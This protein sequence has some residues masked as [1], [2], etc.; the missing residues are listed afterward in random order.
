MPAWW[1]LD[2]IPPSFTVSGVNL[3]IKLMGIDYVNSHISGINGAVII[4]LWLISSVHHLSNLSGFGKILIQFRTQTGLLSARDGPHVG[5][6]N[7]TIRDKLRMVVFMFPNPCGCHTCC[8]VPLRAHT[9]VTQPKQIK[10]NMGYVCGNTWYRFIRVW[11]MFIKWFLGI[12]ICSEQMIIHYL[13]QWCIG[14]LTHIWV[15]WPRWC[16]L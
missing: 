2:G 10:S 12:F 13:N 7:L 14:L 3:T 5:P 9:C 11:I 6:M 8:T 1:L 15:T 4:K 16:N